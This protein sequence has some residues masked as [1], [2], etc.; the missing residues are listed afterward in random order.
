MPA[1]QR[2]PPVP[3][4]QRHL[5][6]L[7]SLRQRQLRTAFLHGRR[8]TWRDRRRI[9]PA[10]LVGALIVGLLLAGGSLL[11]AFQHQQQVDSVHNSSPS[12]IGLSRTPI[13]R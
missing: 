8:R 13:S 9:W 5:L 10:V 11:A 3:Q 1:E 6:A 4:A 2:L 7:H 12:S